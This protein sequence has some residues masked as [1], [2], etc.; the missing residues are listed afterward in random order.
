MI[1]R[2][3]II[4]SSV[5]KQFMLISATV[6]K[7]QK[8]TVSILPPVACVRRPN[9]FVGMRVECLRSSAYGAI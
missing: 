4:Q 6:Q 3:I 8:C 9:S 1:I 7:L 2:V 5:A